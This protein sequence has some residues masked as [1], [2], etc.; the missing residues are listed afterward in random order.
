M[1]NIKIIF[2]KIILLPS[3][4]FNF[5]IIKLK[6]IKYLNYPEINGSI[7]I[8]GRG[9]IFFGKKV[10]INSSFTINPVGLNNKTAFYTSPNSQIIIGNNVGISNTL[11]YALN[12]IKIED[13]VLIGGGCQILDNDFHPLNYDKRILMMILKLNPSL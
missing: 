3:W 10:K 6:K 1:K 7:I 2:L 12:S 11:F 4:V 13:N 9:K 5:I 8:R